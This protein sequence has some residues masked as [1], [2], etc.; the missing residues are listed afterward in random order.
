MQ[1]V[2]TRTHHAT[3]TTLISIEELSRASL[4][5]M[6]S[7]CWRVAPPNDMLKHANDGSKRGEKAR[8]PTLSHVG[9]GA[10]AIATSSKRATSGS[11]ASRS[12]S[13]EFRGSRVHWR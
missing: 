8:S 1:D 5:F 9:L 7:P 3:V 11:N 10:P 12:L 2:D 13:F 4:Q 6:T